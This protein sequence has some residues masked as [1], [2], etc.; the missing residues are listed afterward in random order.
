MAS[1]D[2]PLSGQF[3]SPVA[4]AWMD[5]LLLSSSQNKIQGILHCASFNRP[6]QECQ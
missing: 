2:S 6:Q 3:S 4:K 1:S 5:D